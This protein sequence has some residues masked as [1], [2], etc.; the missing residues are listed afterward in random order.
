[1]RDCLMKREGLRVLVLLLAACLLLAAFRAW[2]CPSGEFNDLNVWLLRKGMSKE[3][4]LSL[5]GPAE[6]ITADFAPRISDRDSPGGERPVV[7]GSVFLKWSRGRNLI[8]GEGEELYVGLTDGKV[9]D[10]YHWVPSF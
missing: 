2:V 4:V 1:M 5:L 9:A 8:G 6:E 10:I 3:G 7:T